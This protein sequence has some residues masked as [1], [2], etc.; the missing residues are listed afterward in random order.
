MRYSPLAVAAAALL[1]L[2]TA[3]AAQQP[4]AS[5]LETG[6]WTGK[7]TP[8]EGITVDVT[9]DVA[10]AGDTLKININA[11]EHGTFNTTDVKLE[12]DKLSFRF[13]PGPE[14]VCVLNKKE[15]GYAGTCTGEDG[16]VA[17]ME[18]SPP[19]KTTPGT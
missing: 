2:S 5:K 1:V 10:Y 14:V 18:L 6:A 8:P 19:K 17:T 15:L 4:A 7:V 13:R 9:Y 3:A 16:S 11:G 12:A